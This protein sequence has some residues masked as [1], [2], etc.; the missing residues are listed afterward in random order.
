MIRRSTLW[1][2]L[3]VL[4][5]GHA[6]KLSAHALQPAYLEIESL[7]SG[8]YR[9]LWRVPD[10]AGR[11]MPIAVDLPEVCRSE[12]PAPSFDGIAWVAIWIADCQATIAGKG[13]GIE[14]LERTQTDVLLRY[15]PAPAAVM[16][17]RRLTPDAPRLTLP[18]KAA[19][20]QVMTVYGL[21][22]FEHI[23]EGLDHLL[24]VLLLMLLLRRFWRLAGAITSFTLAHSLTLAAAT[25]DWI[26]VPAPP[27]EATIA[28][29]IMVLAVE[30]LRADPLRPS[31]LVRR[32]WL[33]CF[34]FGLLHGLGF[35]GAL[36]EIGLPEG[37]TALALLFFNLGVEAGQLTF[38]LAVAALLRGLALLHRDGQALVLGRGGVVIFAY[39]TGG[40]SGYWFIARVAS[41]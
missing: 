32:P 13:I 8:A 31:P 36:R 25:L 21:L 14:G 28:L 11:P 33:I 6:G 1:L 4:I 30:Y 5:C 26:R 20:L 17:V 24:F 15:Q 39:L 22:G 7:D 9:I 35:A 37:E 40:L 41:F 23:L 27:V 10:V 29:S 38:V 34:P 12:G 16:Q 19:P 18:A 2:I 3:L